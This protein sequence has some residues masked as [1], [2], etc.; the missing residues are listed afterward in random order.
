[1]RLR[2]NDVS[3]SCSQSNQQRQQNRQQNRCTAVVRGR[4]RQWQSERHIADAERYLREERAGQRD[5][6]R[7]R[8]TFSHRDEDKNEAVK[9]N[10]RCAE[11]VR[12]LNRGAR[13]G[14]EHAAFV[15][16]ADAAPQNEC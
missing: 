16:D 9:E 3:M 14:V 10:D 4:H 13:R 1:M 6:Q 12:E 7:P 15:V 8:F 2:G 5:G 11:T